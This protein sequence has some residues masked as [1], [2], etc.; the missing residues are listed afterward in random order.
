MGVGVGW[1]C[2]AAHEHLAVLEL[3]AA[4]EQR[5]KHV[6]QQ[7]HALL[8]GDAADEAQ[9]GHVGAHARRAEAA[10]LQRR[11]GLGVAVAV[12]MA[13]GVTVGITEG[14][15]RA[16]AVGVLVSSLQGVAV[17]L[18]LPRRVGAR[19]RERQR[20]LQLSLARGEADAR[21]APGEGSGEAEGE[22]E[23]RG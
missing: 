1:V 22:G 17:R 15:A 14:V 5:G 11:L 21:R 6:E 19:E 3:A 4:E 10:P 16:E 13:E 9:E 2:L 7:V 23:G 18:A 20:Q 12:R 8:R